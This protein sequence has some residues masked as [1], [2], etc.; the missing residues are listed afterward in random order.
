MPRKSDSGKFIISA[1]EVGSFV[2]CPEAWRLKE[3]EKCIAKRHQDSPDGTEKHSEWA[4]N[5]DYYHFVRRAWPHIIL[6]IIL[7]VISKF[8]F[9][10]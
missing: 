5:L 10:K 3:I 6:L 9:Q 2:V 1:S 4:K 8:I 7:A